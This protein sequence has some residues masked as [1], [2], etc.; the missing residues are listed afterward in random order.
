MVRELMVPEPFTNWLQC[1]RTLFIKPLNEEEQK[2]A[3]K[4]R[5]LYGK[6]EIIS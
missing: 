6:H 4:Y 5:F 1:K 2:S 3:E